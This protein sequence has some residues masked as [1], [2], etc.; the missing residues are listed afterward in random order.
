MER[1]V[2]SL[3]LRL[4]DLSLYPLARVAS[5]NSNN[6]RAERRAPERLAD[7]SIPES[8]RF[9]SV[10]GVDTNYERFVLRANESCVNRAL[11]Q[12]GEPHRGSQGRVFLTINSDDTCL[13]W[14][15]TDARS[16]RRQCRGSMSAST[17]SC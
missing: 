6:D 17:R 13:L 1:G 12:A 3:Y 11:D 15:R 9:T 2:V 4:S 7:L 10:C 14:F 5:S 16:H 8:R